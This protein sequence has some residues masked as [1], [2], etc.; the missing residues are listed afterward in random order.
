MRTLIFFSF[1]CLTGLFATA[2][3]QTQIIGDSVR[4]H[5]N[6]GSGELNLENSTDSV[7]GFLFNTGKGRTQFRRGL[8]KMSDTLYMIGADTLII[9]P[10][11]ANTTPTLA[12]VLTQGNQAIAGTATNP[13]IVMQP[14]T[15][16]T[17]PQTGAVEYDGIGYYITD[18][19]GVRHDLT[20]TNRI[21]KIYS[22]DYDSYDSDST[23][24]YTL[25]GWNASYSGDANSAP[26]IASTMDFE[27]TVP[28]G[29]PAGTV[30]T[31]QLQGTTIYTLT[32][33]GAVA[34]DSYVIGMT[35]INQDI[36]YPNLY[37]IRGAVETIDSS[38]SVSSRNTAY[39]LYP[40]SF[41]NPTLVLSV[42]NSGGSI[43][44]IGSTYTIDKKQQG[45]WLFE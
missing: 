18:S 32:V 2:Q 25:I 15:L 1:F 19:T 13:P 10:A 9:H 42:S 44:R 6:T 11:A 3:V 4:I 33:T 43:V 26:T 34:N 41:S 36:K 12:N 20:Q 38:G 29:T 22:L 23:H 31:V 35:V 17:T 7:L 24:T 8:V 45:H 40:E 37:Y 16:T 21:F 14:G 28:S 30:V 27:I 39:R 5:G